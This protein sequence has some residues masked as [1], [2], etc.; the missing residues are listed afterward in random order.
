[1][2][3]AEVSLHDNRYVL[4]AA[5]MLYSKTGHSYE[6]SGGI[7]TVHHVHDINGKPVIGA[8]RPMTEDD[9]LAM[10]KVL[11]PQERPQME[12][13]DNRILAK[14]MGKMIWWTPPMKR[15]MF[16]EE[17]N[18]FGSST[19]D[20]RA[21]CPVP[22][23]VWMTDGRSLFVYAYRG[24]AMPGKETELCQAPLFNVWARGEVCVGNAVVPDDSAKGKPE[25][26]EN[27]LF[28]SNFTHPNFSEVDRLTKGVKP[29]EFWKMMIKK[30]SRTF[31]ETVLVSLDLKVEDLMEPDIKTRLNKIRAKGEF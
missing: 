20:G 19:F 14:G 8:G 18:M 27:F 9:Y 11:A 23:M 5:V 4:G 17:S 22:G 16:F 30:P 29:T 3:K 21:V 13:Q 28:G 1:M 10:V 6:A 7:A 12:W 24:N 26:W 15:A 25:A 2:E 31:P